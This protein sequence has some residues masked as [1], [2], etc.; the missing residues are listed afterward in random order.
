MIT[1]AVALVL[2]HAFELLELRRIKAHAATDNAA[3]RHVLEAN[4]LTEQGLERLR[5]VLPEGRVDAVLYDEVL[6]EEWSRRTS[7]TGS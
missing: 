5:S 2:E 6:R 3:S 4:G 1:A 7:V